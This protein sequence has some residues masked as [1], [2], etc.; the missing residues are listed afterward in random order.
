MRISGAV[1]GKTIQ[2]DPETQTISF[3]V[4]HVT[5]KMDE[6]REIGGLARALH[7]AVNDPNANRLPVIVRNQPIPDLLQDEAQAIMTGKLG[8]DGV[9][10]ADELQLKCPSKYESA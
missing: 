6:L 2:F 1:I 8:T 7:L 5:D 3:T 10:Y 4:A 9:F